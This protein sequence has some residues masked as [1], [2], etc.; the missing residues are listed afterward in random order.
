MD[1]PS[2]I[3][4][5]SCENCHDNREENLGFY[6]VSQFRVVLIPGTPASLFCLVLGYVT[7][8]RQGNLMDSGLIH[9]F[10]ER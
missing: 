8:V 1:Y 3:I 7:V 9:A 2:Q 4:R 6:H 5:L 10:I